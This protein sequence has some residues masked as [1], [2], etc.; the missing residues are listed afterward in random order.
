MDARRTILIEN[1]MI[2]LGQL[3]KSLFPQRQGVHKKK[4]VLENMQKKR[5]SQIGTRKKWTEKEKSM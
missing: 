2:Y 1:R 3:E 5:T 4:E